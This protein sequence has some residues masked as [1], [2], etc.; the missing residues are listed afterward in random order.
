MRRSLGSSSSDGGTRQGLSGISR[1]FPGSPG[2]IP[3]RAIIVVMASSFFLFS[4]GVASAE[5]LPVDIGAVGQQEGYDDAVTARFTTEL[6]TEEADAATRVIAENAQARRE[7][8]LGSLFGTAG[9]A[10][11]EDASSRVMGLAEEYALFSEQ[12]RYG[13]GST[14]VGAE[15][16]PWWLVAV[17][18]GFCGV[19]GFVIAYGLL[20]RRRRQEG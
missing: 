18:F 13:S 14:A 15:V 12:T 6:F 8:S 4:G 10:R 7:E 3:L 1:V 2:G 9:G 16:L 20:E 11:D 19:G 5:D 17:V